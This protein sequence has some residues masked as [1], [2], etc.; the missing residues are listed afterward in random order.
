MKKILM[1]AVAMCMAVSVSA[2]H[3]VGSISLIPK[4]GFNLA[5]L[6]GDVNGNSIKFGFVGGADVMYQLSDLVGLSGGALFS[7]QGA[8]GEGDN[9]FSLFEINI[10]LL[11]NFYVTK[12]FALKVGLQPGIIAS[13]KSKSGNV[14]TTVT[15]SCQTIELSI[16][17]GASYEYKDF[18]FDARYNLGVSKINKSN[19]SQRNSVFQF[20]VGYK[21]DL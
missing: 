5:N 15:S 8:E 20:T 2:Q 10:P 16:P 3:S 11:A 19:G 7:M 12:N 18:V 4:A 6:A 9:S 17:F 13:A 14:T 21:F 1:L